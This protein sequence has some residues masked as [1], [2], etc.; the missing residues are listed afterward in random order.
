MLPQEFYR[1]PP[2]QALNS[3][4]LDKI[5]N[6]NHVKLQTACVVRPLAAKCSKSMSSY[7]QER[8]FRSGMHEEKTRLYNK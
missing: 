5:S 1:L 6:Y 7:P 2:P 8:V 4:S 3:S